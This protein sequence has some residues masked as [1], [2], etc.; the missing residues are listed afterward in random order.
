[1]HCTADVCT[2]ELTTIMACTNDIWN[3]IPPS[4]Y[5]QSKE[6]VLRIYRWLSKGLVGHHDSFLVD[7]R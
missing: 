5:F 6:I 3:L 2:E 1:M 4:D 7:A